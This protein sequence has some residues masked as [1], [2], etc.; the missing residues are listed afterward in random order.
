MRIGN[1]DY[2]FLTLAHADRPLDLAG[3]MSVPLGAAGCR[4]QV[5]GRRWRG[6]TAKSTARSMVRGAGGIRRCDVSDAS[7]HGRRHGR[8][9]PREAAARCEWRCPGAPDD[10]EERTGDQSEHGGASGIPRSRILYRVFEGDT[11]PSPGASKGR[12]S[13][14]CI[15]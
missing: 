5:V 12:E 9:I 7:E 6:S 15:S 13:G 2:F 3:G 14:F 1:K 4:S 11:C 8:M 10:E